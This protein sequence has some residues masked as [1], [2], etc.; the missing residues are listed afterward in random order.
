MGNEARDDS[1]TLA[2]AKGALGRLKQYAS[3]VK[4]ETKRV[5][6]PGLQEVYGTTVMVILT[7][8]LFGIYFYFC[9]MG[10]G[11]AV[12]SLLDYFLHRG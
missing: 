12:K 11:K 10:F 7:T 1:S 4:T 3:E 2:Q 8:F 6:W 9:D 5:T